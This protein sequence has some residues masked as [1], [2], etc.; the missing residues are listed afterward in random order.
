M[1]YSFNEL[2]KFN[3]W[4]RV[5]VGMSLFVDSN[6]AELSP[7]M[8]HLKKAVVTLKIYCFERIIQNFFFQIIKINNA[9]I[10]PIL[11]KNKQLH[12][13]KYYNY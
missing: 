7:A 5:S 8:F 4:L 11:D 12:F 10:P 13:K 2:I 1:L 9:K 3:K 6:I